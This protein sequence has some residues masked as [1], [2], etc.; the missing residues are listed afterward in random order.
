MGTP[1]GK[2]FK[3][4]YFINV[5]QDIFYGF[6]EGRLDTNLINLGLFSPPLMIAL[7]TVS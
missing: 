5:S 7:K 1:W 3:I 4:W 2:S 6:R